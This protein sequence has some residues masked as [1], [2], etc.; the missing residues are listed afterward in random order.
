M[1][2]PAC[3]S[4]LIMRPKNALYISPISRYFGTYIVTGSEGLHEL[5]DEAFE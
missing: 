1:V 4:P 5:G 2:L 3:K